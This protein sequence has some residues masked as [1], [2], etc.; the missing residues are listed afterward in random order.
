MAEV[1]GLGQRQWEAFCSEA[2]P[3]DHDDDCK[4][5]IND[6]D[7][8]LMQNMLTILFVFWSWIGINK[9]LNVF[10]KEIMDEMNNV[11]I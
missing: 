3:G 4:V 10:K 5:V 8:D 2:C 9:T 6:H 11:Q 7:D 1:A